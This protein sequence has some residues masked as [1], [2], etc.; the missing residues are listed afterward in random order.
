ML[1]TERKTGVITGSNNASCSGH[2]EITV[3]VRF[4]THL[5]VK[6]SD[7]DHTDTHFRSRVTVFYY[8]QRSKYDT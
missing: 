6:V 1:C 5:D 3:C 4:Q 2:T 8:S 7:S